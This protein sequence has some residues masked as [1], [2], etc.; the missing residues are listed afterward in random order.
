MAVAEE[1]SRTQRL[2]KRILDEQYAICVE[3]ARYVTE[4]Y[5]RTEGEHPSIRAAKAFENTLRKK[6]VFI[7]DEELI[8]GNH[9]SALVGTLLPV[10]RGEMNLVLEMD[11]E[12]LLNRPDRPYRI[13]PDDKKEL[14]N[15]ILPYW[16][17]KTVRDGKRR[18]FERDGL[19]IKPGFTPFALFDL[20]RSFGAARLAESLSVFAKGRWRALPRSAAEL[21]VNNPNMVNNVFDTQGHLVI[22]HNNVARCGFKGLRDMAAR[23]LEQPV[24]EEGRKFL[25]ATII[26]CDA[27][28]MFAKRYSDLAARMAENEND[29][30][31]REELR[32]IARHTSRAPWLPPE[33]FHEAVQSLWLA[34]VM[35]GISYGLAGICAVG[36]LDQILFPFY[37]KDVESG[38]ISE[39]RALELV[40]ELLV[41]LSVNLIP[42]PSFGKNSGSEMGADSMAPTFGGAGPDGEDASNEL[43]LLFLDAVKN[44]EGM[45]NSYS[46]RVSSKTPPEFLA[47][48][49]EVHAATSGLAL[50]NDDV[51][52]P[53]L[54][55]LGCSTEDARDY[56]IIGCVEP[57]S[58][59][60][61]FGCTSGNDISLAGVLEMVFT[62]GRIRMAGRRA[63]PR[64]GDPAK[65]N[66]FVQFLDAFRRQLSFTVAH[67]ARCVNAKDE[68]YA[69]GFHNPFIS[70]TLEGCIRNAEDMTQGGAKYNYASIS[71]RGLGTV[72]DSLTAIKK[73]VFDEKKYT[74]KEL[75]AALKTNFRGREKM[76][77]FLSSRTPRYGSDN[78]EAD[79]MAREVAAMFCEEVAK[80]KSIRKG[81]AFRPGFF[82]YGMHVLDGS[83]LGAT[84]DGRLAGQPVSNSLSPVNGAESLGPTA[85]MRSVASLEHSKITNGSSLN[86]KLMPGVFKNEENR[87]K[88]EA[89]L[90]GYFSLGGMHVQFNV[91]DDE[92]L[93]A[94][95]L[96]PDSHRGL[97]V[98]VSGY[99]AYFTDLGRPLQDDI[100][101]RVSFGDI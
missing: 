87:R 31:R 97:L 98:R 14:L 94:A 8:A 75:S 89:M 59:G 90:R 40:E 45:S 37:K 61:T 65:F 2:R 82:S 34:Q 81:G 66:S 10:E 19:I 79:A 48:I 68:V 96:D 74:M 18:L 21:P 47:K 93:R 22:G 4:S 92:T 20:V 30:A 60:N 26:C 77:A 17:G 69:A 80:H 62:Q 57:T 52:I 85:V 83:L 86:M 76:R 35:C 5:R 70:A 71:A 44:I 7:L 33:S 54:E 101:N 36:R 55:E 78:P 38:A 46:V 53:M 95:Q 58:Q 43:S 56:A 73:F 49:S 25:E 9:N 6:T 72:A 51:I 11:I 67:I 32:L 50:F 29:P 39:T 23:R 12:N 3:R 28:R 13:D 84:P 91:V 99:S 24:T 16:R 42:L 27:A 41:K 64:T 1:K 63:G 88:F 15:D 100:I